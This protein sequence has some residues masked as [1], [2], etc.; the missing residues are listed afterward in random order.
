MGRRVLRT[1]I[2]APAPSA[3]RIDAVLDAA[4]GPRGGLSIELGGGRTASVR[5]RRIR[6]G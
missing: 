2:G 1:A 5:A 3:E 6:L 4:A